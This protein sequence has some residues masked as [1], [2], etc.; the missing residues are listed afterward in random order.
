MWGL[1]SLRLRKEMLF[2]Y[3]LRY[4]FSVQFGLLS[5]QISILALKFYLISNANPKQLEAVHGVG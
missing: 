1:L 2:R 4:I 3:W 5:I